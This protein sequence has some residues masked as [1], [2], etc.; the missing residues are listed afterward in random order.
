[1]ATSAILT[2]AENTLLPRDR[3]AGALIRTRLDRLAAAAAAAVAAARREDE[4]ELR[5]Q[6]SRFEALTS[7]IW[8][9]HEGL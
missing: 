1:M 6:L 5:R 9:V 3:R 2:E 4:A 7:A 8:V